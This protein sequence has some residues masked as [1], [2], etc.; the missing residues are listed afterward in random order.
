MAREFFNAYHSYLKSIEPYNDAERGRLFTALLVY[1]STGEVPELRGNERFLFPTMKEQIDRDCKAYAKKCEKQSQNARM[2]WHPGA[3]QGV[4]ADAAPAKETDK[5][6]TKEKEALSCESGAMRADAPQKAGFSPPALEDVRAYC[7]ARGSTVD[8]ERFYHYYAANGWHVG[9][10][11]MQDWR[12]AVAAW[13]RSEKD[14]SA[15]R[16]QDTN[17]FFGGDL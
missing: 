6:K 13:E 2:R 1:S 17:P 8:P 16:A 4:P 3:C 15:P 9:R 7:R 12:R 11:K 10:S 5:A 14:R